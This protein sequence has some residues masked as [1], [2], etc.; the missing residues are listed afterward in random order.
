M[1]TTQVP[2]MLLRWSF[3]LLY[4]QLAW[5]YDAVAWGVSLGQ[6]KAWGRTIFPYLRGPRVL[7]LAH[8]PGH[9]LTAMRAAG[10]QSV[11]YDLSPSMGR[12]ARRNMAHRGVAIPLALGLAQ[13]LPFP[14]GTFNSVVSTFPAEFILHPVTWREVARVLAPDGIFIVVPTAFLTGLGPLERLQA[15]LVA[16]AGGQPS[17]EINLPPHF[18]AA[19]FTSEVEWISLRRGRVM[20][21][22]NYPRSDRPGSRDSDR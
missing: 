12:L 19:G 14:T 2:R 5:A 17:G 13:E 10:Y 11:G 15:S 7:D 18:A 20:L 9:L 6:W 8:G 21:I 1:I 16:P 22:L 4:N 3:R